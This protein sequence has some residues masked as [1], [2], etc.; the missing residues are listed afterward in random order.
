[1]KANDGNDAAQMGPEILRSD[2]VQR[3]KLRW[4]IATKIAVVLLLWLFGLFT[5][6]HATDTH[7]THAL[8]R[9]LKMVFYGLGA[10]LLLTAAYAAWH[11]SRIFA[12]SQSRPPS[13]WVLR[14]TQLLRGDRARGRGWLALACAV[15]SPLLAA[16]AAILPSQI[17][18]TM[19]PASV[20]HA[21][22][23]AWPHG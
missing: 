14:D 21:A 7:D 17:E 8:A 22:R 15:V 3:R 12:S 10:L 20:H 5:L 6:K 13:S 18:R 16:Y 2:P 11:A 9:Q 19:K 23:I 1:M 4:M